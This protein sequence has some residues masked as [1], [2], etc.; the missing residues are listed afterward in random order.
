MMSVVTADGTTAA[1]RIAAI[2]HGG[3][4]TSAA[5]GGWFIG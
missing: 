1:A 3:K 4:C 2:A 5:A